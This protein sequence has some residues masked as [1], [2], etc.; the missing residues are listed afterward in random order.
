VRLFSPDSR[1]VNDRCTDSTLA[2]SVAVYG[3]HHVYG[4]HTWEEYTTTLAVA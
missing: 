3:D 4:D 1:L 2:I